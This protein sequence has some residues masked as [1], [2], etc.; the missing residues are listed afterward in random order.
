MESKGARKKQKEPERARRSQEEQGRARRSQEEPGGAGRSQE[1]P[2]GATR[3][4]EKPAGARINRGGQEKPGGAWS[5]QGSMS[6]GRQ[7]LAPIHF[8]HEQRASP[9]PPTSWAREKLGPT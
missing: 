3:S 9:G 8:M 5:F 7:F 6:Y 1:E 4:K 2:Q